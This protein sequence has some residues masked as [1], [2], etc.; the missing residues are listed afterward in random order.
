MR[1]LA[2]V[3]GGLKS[4]VI[5]ETFIH[6]LF[7]VFITLTPILSRTDN[8]PFSAFFS[9]WHFVFTNALLAIQFYLNA[10]FLIPVILNKQKRI[11]LYFVLF[12]ISFITI[13]LLLKHSR[14]DIHFPAGRV[15]FGIPP[16]PPF[17][18]M[19]SL[20]PL[21][22]ISAAGFAY[23][24]LADSFR[25][26]SYEQEI[27]NTSLVSELAFL[28]SQISPHFIFNVINSIVSLSRLNPQYVEPALI[29]LSGLMRYMLYVSDEQKVTLGNK[30]DYLR[31]YIELQKMRF[32]D[33][34]NVNMTFNISHPEKTIEPML[35]I[36]FVENAF[37][38]GAFEAAD[39]TVNILLRADDKTLFFSVENSFDAT[40]T[41]KDE[42][43]G[44][45][46]ANVKRRLELLYPGKY[47]LIIKHQDSLYIV[48]LQLQ[49]K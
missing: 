15:P 27:K 1:K 32:Q 14:P 4:A 19:F 9:P 34:I 48:N 46:L 25:M 36:P 21:T 49:L 38:H 44:I 13:Y 41:E 30:M 43:H 37:K 23:R 26:I 47:K 28:R 22:A 16:K 8:S 17:I 45:G 3:Y 7:W 5:I 24:Y 18:S 20:L 40:E 6:V 2:F 12:L 35:L 29:Q 10:F 11:G 39:A 42:N 33:G 31:S